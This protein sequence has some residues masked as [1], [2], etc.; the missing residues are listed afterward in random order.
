LKK[1]GY[2]L[3]PC[4]D[5]AGEYFCFQNQS[6]NTFCS[7]STGASCCTQRMGRWRYTL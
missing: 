5:T 4:G 6:K 2:F 7:C 1:V 3:F